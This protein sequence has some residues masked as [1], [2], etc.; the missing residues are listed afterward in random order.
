[1]EVE[2]TTLTLGE[3]ADVDDTLR[4]DAHSLEGRLVGEAVFPNIQV[5]ASFDPVTPGWRRRPR[6]P[7]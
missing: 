5:V 7:W 4:L 3:S 1:M 2:K 6:P